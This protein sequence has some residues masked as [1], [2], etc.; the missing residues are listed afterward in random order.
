MEEAYCVLGD[1]IGEPCFGLIQVNSHISCTTV[2]V[3]N[4][5]YDLNI[6]SASLAEVENIINKEEASVSFFKKTK[7]KSH[8]R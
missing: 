8:G 4:I 6:C 7:T 2:R 1:S 3:K 5:T